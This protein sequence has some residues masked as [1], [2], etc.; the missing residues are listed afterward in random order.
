[1]IS[2]GSDIE[3]DIE[4]LEEIVKGNK[5]CLAI[6]L[7][8]NNKDDIEHWEKEIN[9][10]ENIVNAYYRE[11][12]RAD[13]LEKDYSKL[14]TEKDEEEAKVKELEEQVEYDKTHIFTPTTIN[15][16]YIPKKKIKDMFEESQTL[17]EKKL[18]EIDFKELKNISLNIFEGIKLEVERGLL[19]RLLQESEDK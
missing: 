5:E 8:N 11:K 17:Y 15:L 19:R 18:K 13:K 4:T 3:E 9:A 16:N 10:I 12:A 14:L 1:M 2:K 7:R 6:D